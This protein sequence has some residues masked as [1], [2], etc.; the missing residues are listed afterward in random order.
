MDV[1]DSTVRLSHFHVVV[2]TCNVYQHVLATQ[3]N[4]DLAVTYV[5]SLYIDV[6]ELYV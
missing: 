4:V 3:R 5:L 2:R 1:T 6:S